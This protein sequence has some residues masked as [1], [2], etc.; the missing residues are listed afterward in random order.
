MNITVSHTSTLF[1]YT[2]ISFIAGS[3]THG[4]FTGQRSIITAIIG[5]VFF[6]IG[7]VLENIGKTGRSQSWTR[8]LLIGIIGSVG[9]G[10]FTG[11]L[12]HF[13]DSPDRSVWVVPL[14]FIVSLIAL[15][16]TEGKEKIGRESFTK[17]ALIGTIAVALLS[18]GALHLFDDHDDHDDDHHKGVVK[19]QPSKV[20]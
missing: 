13:P 7:T 1:K 4:A 18:Y 12:Q 14:G 19:V 6:V 9:L 3:V 5:V 16:L 20:E 10:L 17:Y 11:G 15:Y 8:L 2:G